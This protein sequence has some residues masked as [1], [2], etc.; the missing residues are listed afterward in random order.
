MNPDG[1]SLVMESDTIIHQSHGSEANKLY[2][3]NGLYY[4]FFS[5]VKNE[6]RVI[7]MER[8]KSLKGAW[9]IRQLNHVH[10][11]VDREPNQ[12]GLLQAPDF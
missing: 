6:G 7:M 12:G 10:G 2:K 4:H 11:K 9:G 5:E 3:M 8:S 1:R